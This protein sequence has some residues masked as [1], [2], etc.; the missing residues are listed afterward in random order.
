MNS[1]MYMAGNTT[2]AESL[3]PMTW[4]VVNAASDMRMPV[5]QITDCATA[6]AADVMRMGATNRSTH[7]APPGAP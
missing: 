5:D 2:A 3:L 4:Y 1:N 7:N 6:V